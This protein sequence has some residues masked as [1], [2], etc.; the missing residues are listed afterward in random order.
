MYDTGFETPKDKKDTR[1]PEE[2]ER[3]NLERQEGLN[4]MYSADRL[5][6]GRSDVD[7]SKIFDVMEHQNRA[8]QV[9]VDEARSEIADVYDQMATAGS[10]ESQTLYAQEAEVAAQVENLTG[11]AVDTQTVATRV[12]AEVLDNVADGSAD[13]HNRAQ[14]SAEDMATV[15]H[16]T[17]AAQLFEGI[18][19]K[20][21]AFD[22]FSTDTTSRLDRYTQMIRNEG[23]VAKTSSEKLDEAGRYI[24]RN[25]EVQGA[26]E[27][28][29]SLGTDAE[30]LVQA[31]ASGDQLGVRRELDTIPEGVRRNVEAY[32]TASFATDAQDPRE[33]AAGLKEM[34][35]AEE[36][37]DR[38]A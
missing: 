32:L 14:L 1:T 31:W 15:V 21:E 7:E 6:A 29:E 36:S 11:V 4:D 25:P 30:K 10:P 24:A 17:A 8:E 18:E 23:G 22:N 9:G 3:D 26:P 35:P 16:A 12:G 34:L 27:T 38:A 28:E 33:I 5:Q 2:I 13:E 20:S 37:S 19:G